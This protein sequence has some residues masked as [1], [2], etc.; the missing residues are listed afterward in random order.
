MLAQNIV[1]STIQ[2]VLLRIYVQARPR[3]GSDEK[4]SIFESNIP[5]WHQ[6][7]YNPWGEEKAVMCIYAHQNAKVECQK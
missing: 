4:G 5:D 2:S 3:V 6:R 1:S 7:I